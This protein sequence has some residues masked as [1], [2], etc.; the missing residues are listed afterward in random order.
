MSTFNRTLLV[1]LAIAV[2]ALWISLPATASPSPIEPVHR[3]IAGCPTFP[4]NNYWHAKVRDL[5]KHP[6]SDQWLRHMS[7]RSKLHPD[8]GPSYG[9]QRVPYGIPI[10]VVGGKH[11]KV[12]VSFTYRRESDR[13][14][15][16]L[17]T[18]TRIE[19]GKNASGDRHAIVVDKSDCTLFE[20]W[21]TK[22]KSSG[23][24]AGSGAVWDLRSNALRRD[25]WTSAD[26]AG[27]PILP[28]L[29]RW[30]EVK[31]GKVNH[32][33]RFTTDVTDRRY[34][35]PARHQAG[36]VNNRK[37]P[38]MGA[39]FRLKA[40]FDVNTYSPRTRTVLRAMKDYGL[41]LAD[42]GS[43]WYFQGDSNKHW[44]SESHQPA[45]ADPSTRVRCRRCGGAEGRKQQW[46]G[47]W[48][49]TARTPS[50]AAKPSSPTPDTRSTIASVRVP[51]RL[52]TRAAVAASARN[53]AALPRPTPTK[54]AT[55]PSGVE[56][57]E[58]VVAAPKIAAHEIMVSGLEAVAKTP[59]RQ[60]TPGAA[61]SAAVSPPSRNRH[62]VCSVRT[63]I[64]VST[65]APPRASAVWTGSICTNAAAPSTPR[66]A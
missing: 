18:D 25:G 40:A 53:Q 30:R 42:N 2:P 59:V 12:N 11:K 20:T 31:A 63:P 65:T 57:S 58:A 51:N 7:P 5:P 26:A 43:P 23:W 34:V 14:K 39:R 21:N 44:S 22:H 50:S 9:A 24:H 17:G 3:P 4:T 66:S 64:T 33:I 49:L 29:L 37:Y 38:P 15:Y 56:T 52:P 45:Q 8:F 36:S 61:T 16:P 6:R 35:W 62:A 10:T 47:Q 54:S 46:P 48:S 19:G 55:A 32:A 60:A 28:G 27:L 13:V 1:S 41:V